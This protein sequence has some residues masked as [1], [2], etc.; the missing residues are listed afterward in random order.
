MLHT[1][2]SCTSSPFTACTG[3]FQHCRFVMFFLLNNFP[4]PSSVSR[5][6]AVFTDVL[7]CTQIVAVNSVTN[8]LAHP[9][10]LCAS[11]CVCVCVCVCERERERERESAHVRNKTHSCVSF[12]V[13]V[14]RSSQN[15]EYNRRLVLFFLVREINQSSH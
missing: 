5:Y 9:Q 10:G 3:Q 15:A 4:S 1:P 13:C 2:S 14:L 12:C 11:V 8:V 6:P 7:S